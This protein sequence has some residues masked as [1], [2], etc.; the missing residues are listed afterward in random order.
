[1]RLFLLN[2]V[3]F[4]LIACSSNIKTSE[5]DYSRAFDVEITKSPG[6]RPPIGDLMWYDL[7]GVIDNTDRVISIYVISFDRQQHIPQI[8]ERCSLEIKE[9]SPSFDQIPFENSDHGRSAFAPDSLICDKKQ[10]ISI[11]PSYLQ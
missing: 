4:F 6:E 11:R 7:S 3:L 9:I 2:I 1:M 5:Y 10:A 8:G